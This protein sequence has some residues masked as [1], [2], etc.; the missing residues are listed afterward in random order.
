MF[1]LYLLCLVVGGVFVT[2]ASVAGLDGVDF[3]Q[4]FDADVELLDKSDQSS[5]RPTLRIANKR[6]RRGLGLPFLSL[7]FW[8]FG[9]CF[10]GLT[11]VLLSLLNP[12][13]SASLIA[14]ISIA[15]GSGLGTAIVWVLRILQRQQAD[16]LIRSDDLLGLPGIVEI[17]FDRNSKGKVRLNVKGSTL[18]LIA[19][20]E[21]NQEFTQGEQAFIVGVEKNK[22]W[23]V[24]EA[25]FG[26]SSD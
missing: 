17:P 8:T 10:F 13:L 15:V 9:S 1:N 22:V 23:V 12:T 25:A 21:D 4:D 14:G 19:V 2:L 3:D 16:S 20:T 11:G 24:S 5:E 6:R 7:R 18:D 26:R